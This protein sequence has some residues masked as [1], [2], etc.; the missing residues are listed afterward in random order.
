MHIWIIFVDIKNNFLL[1]NISILSK[2]TVVNRAAFPFDL[3]Y[4]QF[5]RYDP[6]KSF[7]LCLLY[8]QLFKINQNF[9]KFG[10][11]LPE[12]TILSIQ[13][14]KEMNKNRIFE[15]KSITKSTLMGKFV[16]EG[17]LRSSLTALILSKGHF[18]QL[19]EYELT[20]S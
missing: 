7:I 5:R 20:Y 16:V 13:N 1:K 2:N 4:L 15:W 19:N 18:S 14:M 8:V 9:R 12:K 17:R 3:Y 6:V 10:L 11:F